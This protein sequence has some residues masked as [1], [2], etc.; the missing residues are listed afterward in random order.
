MNF[1][2]NY[3]KDFVFFGFVIIIYF[4]KMYNFIFLLL[5]KYGSFIMGIKLV[6]R[7]VISLLCND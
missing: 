3:V 6:R 4:R 2:S 1:C 5:L 7:F